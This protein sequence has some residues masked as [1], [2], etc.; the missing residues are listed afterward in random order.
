MVRRDAYFRRCG[1]CFHSATF[2]LPA[3]RKKILYLDQ[4]AISNL[5]K[6]L[7]PST[8]GHARTVADPF[9]AKLFQTLEIAAKMQTDRLSEFRRTPH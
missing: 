3:L 9:W 2:M 6:A 1:G 8:K 5:V 4:F 7:D